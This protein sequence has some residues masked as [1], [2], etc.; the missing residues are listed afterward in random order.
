MYLRLRSVC[1]EE[2]GTG[3]VKQGDDCC[4]VCVKCDD[5]QYVSEDRKSCIKCN[6]GDGPNANKTGCEKLPIEY[7][8]FN[9]AFTLVPVIFSSFGIILTSFTI[10]VF[11]R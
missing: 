8:E 4:W 7:M 1:K 9:T 2:C 6:N 5:T 3:E 11:I 10:G